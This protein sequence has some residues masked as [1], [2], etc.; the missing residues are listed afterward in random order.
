MSGIIY[1]VMSMPVEQTERIAW[2]TPR[3]LR[4][5]DRDAM[6]RPENIQLLFHSLERDGLD[7]R[8]A[9]RLLVQWL[10]DP[11]A[12]RLAGAPVNPGLPAV[13][14]TL[15]ELCWIIGISLAAIVAEEERNT[16]G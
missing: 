9:V 1:F 7:A 14:Q 11:D 3:A 6:A 12:A 13:W 10:L 8:D 5:W 4:L 2:S 15:N 16:D